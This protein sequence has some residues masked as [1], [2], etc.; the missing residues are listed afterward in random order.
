[1]VGVVAVG[2]VLLTADVEHREA[3]VHLVDV[4]PN[5]LP[6]SPFRLQKGRV[7]C[8]AVKGKGREGNLVIGPVTQRADDVLVSLSGEEATRALLCSELGV[9]HAVEE[10]A[11]LVQLGTFG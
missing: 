5:G 2:A 6:G 10:R 9:H 3:L 8:R 4:G 7:S 11:L 1:M